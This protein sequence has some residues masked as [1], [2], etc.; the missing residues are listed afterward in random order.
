M[1]DSSKN[2]FTRKWVDFHLWVGR[3]VVDL[4]VI[5][6]VGQFVSQFVSLVVVPQ[7]QIDQLNNFGLTK[8]D[9]VPWNEF[10]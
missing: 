1:S 6:S 5:S 2:A 4:S 7:K 8:E 3:L 9:S 10:G